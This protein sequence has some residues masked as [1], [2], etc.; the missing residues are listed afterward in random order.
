MSIHRCRHH[1]HAWPDFL[2]DRLAL[3]NRR[4]SLNQ[5]LQDFEFNESQ[6]EVLIPECASGFCHINP[7]IAKTKGGSVLVIIINL[8]TYSQDHFC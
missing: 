5:D 8:V 4:I 7:D 1:F 2:I 6:R 3:T